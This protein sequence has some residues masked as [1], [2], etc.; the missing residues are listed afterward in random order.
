MRTGIPLYR[1]TF[2]SDQ[3]GTLHCNR[4]C[5][6]VASRTYVL[7]NK[8]ERT[9]NDHHTSSISTKAAGCSCMCCS[10][11]FSR[12]LHP[13]DPVDATARSQASLGCLWPGGADYLRAHG[14]EHGLWGPL[15]GSTCV[16]ALHVGIPGTGARTLAPGRLLA[17]PSRA[18]PGLC[19]RPVAAGAQLARPG[20]QRPPAAG[21]RNSPDDSLLD[22]TG[23]VAPEPPPCPA[24]AGA[25]RV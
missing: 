11:F 22:G 17:E 19:A 20:R 12:S 25:Q 15:L 4:S 5:R 16:A 7:I 10:L 21:P 24:P 8:Q 6:A 13:L 18:G 1:L 14:N 23:S 3:L 2:L 9:A